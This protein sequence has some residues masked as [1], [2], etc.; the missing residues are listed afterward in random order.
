MLCVWL[1]AAESAQYLASADDRFFCR[2]VTGGSLQV[3]GARWRRRFGAARKPAVVRCALSPSRRRPGVPRPPQLRPLGGNETEVLDVSLGEE[4]A[5]TGL[6]LV[7]GQGAA[8]HVVLPNAT[9]SLW[10]YPAAGLGYCTAPQP[11]VCVAARPGPPQL[12]LPSPPAEM[13][14]V[15]LSVSHPPPPAT[16]ACRMHAQRVRVPNRAGR[17]VRR[18]HRLLRRPVLPP[19][20]CACTAGHAHASSCSCLLGGQQGPIICRRLCVLSRHDSCTTGVVEVVLSYTGP[21]GSEAYELLPLDP[22]LPLSLVP[23]ECAAVEL[24]GMRAGTCLWLG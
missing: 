8:W 11:G 1:P 22:T 7:D 17:L 23:N 21:D 20:R 4:L 2:M 19:P 24:P 12:V 5:S 6:V 15:T 13:R 18:G 10:L 14:C 16:H 3:G 9:A